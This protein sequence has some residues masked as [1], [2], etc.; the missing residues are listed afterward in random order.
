MYLGMWVTCLDVL[1][2]TLRIPLGKRRLGGD[3]D[4][5]R[6]FCSKRECIDIGL[7]FNEASMSWYLSHDAL[8]FRVSL[9]ANI[10]NI[11]ALRHKVA[12]KIVCA[13]DIGAGGID[14]V[15]PTLLRTLLNQG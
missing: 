13:R 8:W 9:L 6:L 14:A 12:H 7:S 3:G 1:D 15:Q 11:V 4:V 10:E 2:D 5:C